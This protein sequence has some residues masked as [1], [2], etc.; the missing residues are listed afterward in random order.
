MWGRE[1]VLPPDP[2]AQ[3]HVIG[4]I[5]AERLALF[6]R[7]PPHD[8][9]HQVLMKTPWRG[10]RQN[11]DRPFAAYCRAKFFAKL[12]NFI[13]TQQAGFRELAS[14]RRAL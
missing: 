10:P 13:A 4:P 8:F 2:H 12:A 3:G 14:R 1:C 7:P 5:L 6:C 9:G 11:R